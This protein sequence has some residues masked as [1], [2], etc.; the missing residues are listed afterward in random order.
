MLMLL[1]CSCS[2]VEQDADDAGV[3]D[4][5]R[6]GAVDEDSETGNKAT[7]DELYDPD[8]IQTFE[9]KIDDA[10][11]EAMH[12]A[13]PERIYV[14]AVF[15][16]NEIEIQNVGVRYKGN[17]SS[18]PMASHK[19]SFLIKFNEYVK[20]RRLSGLRR[21]AIDNG[22]QFGSLFSERIITD[23]LRDMGVTT[24]RSNYCRLF[25]NNE[26]KGVYV[27]VERIDNSFLDHHFESDD[28]PLFKCDEGGP[29]A[30]MTFH[31]DDLTVYESTFEE[32]NSEDDKVDTDLAQLVRFL[33]DLN[34]VSDDHAVEFLEKNFELDEFIPLMAVMLY[35]GAFDQLTGWNAHNYYMYK[36]PSDDRWVYIAWDLDVGF[37]DNAFGEIPVLDGWNAAYAYPVAVRPVLKL[38]VENEELL[39]R[40]R[41]HA[42]EILHRYFDPDV[43]VP[44]L[45]RL[46]EQIRPD[47]ENDP[48]P[49]VRVT[50][51]G[52]TDYDSI[53]AS[54]TD[55]IIRRH[56]RAVAELKDPKKTPPAEPDNE[57]PP[58]G[59]PSPDAPGDLRVTGKSAS[60]ISLAWKDN[61]ADEAAF[62][63]QRCTG[64]G[65]TDFQN[66]MGFPQPDLEEA[67]DNTVSAGTVYVYRVYAIKPAPGGPEATGPSNTVEAEAID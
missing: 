36:K 41:Q 66:H 15:S 21:L 37:S 55:F 48:F 60:H 23:V 33:R 53:I 16:W 44:E 65:C 57:I 22:I 42:E 38:V 54:I 20:G 9:L 67:V 6:D 24:M 59:E 61:A 63:V 46:Y 4:S 2:T 35:A 11:L 8:T 14:P 19:R 27:N 31:G 26:Y 29:G 13:L 30:D 18:S 50:N 47:L 58:P 45:N 17:S 12:N 32:K 7:L 51:P 56:E 1:L 49:H 62:I 10:D 64:A 40:Y 3:S 52:D 5:G 43:L 28:G 34:A 25:I 39:K